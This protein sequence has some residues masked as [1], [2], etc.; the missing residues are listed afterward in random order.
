MTLQ[1]NDEDSE[2][3]RSEGQV[4]Y[5]NSRWPS[6]IFKLSISFRLVILNIEPKVN[7]KWESAKNILNAVSKS[8]LMLLVLSKRKQNKNKNEPK[9]LSL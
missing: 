8:N 4:V 7:E 2:C 3:V 1:L 5:I 6:I 9:K